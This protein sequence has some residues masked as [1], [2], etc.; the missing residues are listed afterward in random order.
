M[1]NE[2]EGSS[3]MVGAMTLGSATVGIM[4]GSVAVRTT[5]ASDLASTTVG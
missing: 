2:D 4:F 5:L 1:A 3:A